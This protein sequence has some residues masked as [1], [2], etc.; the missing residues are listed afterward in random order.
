MMTNQEIFDTVAVHLL[1]QNKRATKANCSTTC[2]YRTSEGLKCAVGCLIPDEK[3]TPEMEPYGVYTLIE[4][5]C[6][7]VKAE[8]GPCS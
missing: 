6:L 5:N 2:Q 1:T 8:G 7:D 4:K 3:Y